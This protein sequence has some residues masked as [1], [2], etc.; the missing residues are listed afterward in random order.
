MSEPFKEPPPDKSEEKVAQNKEQPEK[1]KE[2][3]QINIPEEDLRRAATGGVQSNQPDPSVDRSL[4]K[5]DLTFYTGANPGLQSAADQTRIPLRLSEEKPAE[6]HPR[7]MVYKPLINEFLKNT[8]SEAGKKLSDAERRQLNYSREALSNANNLQDA[9]SDALHLARL[10]QHMRYIEEAK[11]A[12]DLSLG[13][14]PDNYYGNQIF[15]ELERMHPAEFGTSAP[16]VEA[17][18]LSKSNLR[19][20]I[21]SLTGGRVI[22]VGDLLIDELLEGKPERISREAPVLILEHVDTELILGGG[23]NTANNIAAMGGQCHA[24]GVCGDDEYARRLEALFDKAHIT[25]GLVRDSSRP[26]TVKTRILSKSHSFK[27]QLLRLDR[28][29][30]D[31]IDAEIE[32]YVLEKVR[33]AAGN[34]GALV[35]SDYRAGIMTDNLIRGCRAI[36]AEKKLFIIVD[37]QDDFARYQ[38]VSLLTPNEPD[39]EQA[40]G[41]ALDS[42]ENITRAGEDLLLM[43]GAEALLITRGAKGVVLFQQGQPM[44]TLPPFNQSAVFDVTGAGDTVVGTMALALVTGSTY[45][46]AMAL[47]NLAAGIVVTKPGTAVTTQKEMLEAL[48]ALKMQE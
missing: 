3:S 17:Q 19:K 15:R 40:L 9:V 28:I 12:I 1:N 42:K 30:H 14:D 24:V 11:K 27:Q 32:H 48:D 47:G 8:D 41:Y 23:A 43:T 33:S 29:C 20:R 36:A 13:I 46:E 7:M 44:V 25:H 31:K 21:L 34:Y 10:Y 16:P 45:V 6:V 18:P 39:A 4:A 2:L 22:V 26:T 5:L 37:A 38:N 35:L